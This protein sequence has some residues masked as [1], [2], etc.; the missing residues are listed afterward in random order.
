MQCVTGRQ[1]EEGGEQR[2]AEGEAEAEEDALEIGLVMQRL[3][4]PAQCEAL[5][6]EGEVARG[7]EGREDDDEDGGEEKE[8]DQPCED[9]EQG[10]DVA[11][12][13]AASVQRRVSMPARP[14]MAS[15][16]VVSRKAS[17]APEGHSS[18]PRKAS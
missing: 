4:E 17:A 8:E 14:M 18:V 12:A 9:R 13:H 2:R 1:R 7:V 10:M 3:G 16:K 6:R 5:G 11:V 15:A